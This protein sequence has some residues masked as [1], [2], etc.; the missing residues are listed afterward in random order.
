M[1][2]IKRLALDRKN[3]TSNRFAVEASD[4]IVTT[5]KVSF[6]LPAGE[7]SDRPTSPQDGEI[8]YNQTNR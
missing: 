5:S 1:K 7:T 8:R 3:Q 6:Q 4:R 2:F